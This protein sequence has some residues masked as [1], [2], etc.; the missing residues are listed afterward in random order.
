M[1]YRRKA[2]VVSLLLDSFLRLLRTA[3]HCFV[4]KNPRS[5]VR[6][7]PLYHKTGKWGMKIGGVSKERNKKWNISDSSC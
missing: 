5:V 7:R 2:S 4:I 1:V 3:L 6:I